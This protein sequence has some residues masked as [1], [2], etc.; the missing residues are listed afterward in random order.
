V[1]AAAT[2]CVKQQQCCSN[3][4]MAGGATIIW[5]RAPD[6]PQGAS[7]LRPLPTAHYNHNVAESAGR[8]GRFTYRGT[9][10]WTMQVHIRKVEGSSPRAHQIDTAVLTVRLKREP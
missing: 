10:R 6:L 1:A 3:H 4:N 7:P 8:R 2:L 5:P 9:T